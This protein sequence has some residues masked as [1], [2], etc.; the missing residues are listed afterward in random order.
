MSA[1]ITLK[2]LTTYKVITMTKG[3]SF[4]TTM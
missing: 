3:G 1:K 4:W 2:K